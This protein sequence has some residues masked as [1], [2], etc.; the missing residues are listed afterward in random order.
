[1]IVLGTADFNVAQHNW[2]IITGYCRTGV[3]NYYKSDARATDEIIWQ[4]PPITT[5]HVYFRV[6]VKNHS[7]D[8]YGLRTGFFAG[9][10]T[11]LGNIR[12]PTT[13]DPHIDIRTGTTVHDSV[14]DVLVTGSWVV[15]EFEQ[16]ATTITVKRNDVII[17]EVTG[18]TADLDAISSFRVAGGATAVDAW[19]GH[20]DDV[21]IT[22]QDWPGLGGI[23]LLEPTDAGVF[24]EWDEG[25]ITDAEIAN[26]KQTFIK[27]PPPMQG[28]YSV[29]AVAVGV[30]ARLT[31]QGYGAV[32][33][34]FGQLEGDIHPL[35]TSTLQDLQ[36]W[37]GPWT[38]AEFNAI[39]FGVASA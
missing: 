21:M 17:S 12:V 39:E 7:S 35:S 20:I 36:A 25:L 15:L 18:I 9:D 1:M 2:S 38:L 24:Q 23:H 19:N 32:K 5:P 11:L 33:P 6:A 28:A 31:G 22:D 4:L 10:G 30:K 13:T 27:D 8:R 34:L 14:N 29:T 37:Y 16:T 3:H 26:K